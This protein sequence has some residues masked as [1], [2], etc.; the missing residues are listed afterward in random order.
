MHNLKYWTCGEYLGLGAAAHS[1]IA[2]GGKQRHSNTESISEYL[3]AVADG[4]KPVIDSVRLIP[5]DERAEYIMLR[6]RLAE[7]FNM[8]DY[9][10]RFGADF[11]HDFS[12]PMHL[13]KK[14]G[15]IDITDNHIIPTLKGYDLQNTL[16][17]EF[18]K[19]I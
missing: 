12:E 19:K 13:L 3:L 10:A 18:M 17:G 5:D 6:L 9:N 11:E 14:A 16:I 2:D 4:K 15:M 1:Y 7:G 8:A